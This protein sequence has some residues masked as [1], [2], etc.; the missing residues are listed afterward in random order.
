MKKLLSALIL[1][2]FFLTSCAS[3][4][5]LSDDT[6][7]N[8][9][10]LAT[11]STAPLPDSAQV[12]SVSEDIK[13]SETTASTA[14]ELTAEDIEK[15]YPGKTVITIS[16]N[17]SFGRQDV[18]S[19]A[20]EYLSSIGKD[21]VIYICP[22]KAEAVKSEYC[23]DSGN[24]TIGQTD[25]DSVI[26]EMS[27]KIDI[28][29]SGNYLKTVEKGILLPLDEYIEGSKLHKFIPEKLWNGVR[30]DGEIY[31]IDCYSQ[32]SPQRGY[33]VDCEL[34]DKYGFDP[35]K[36]LIEQLDVLKAI[37]EKESCTPVI[38]GN[39]FYITNFYLDSI[40]VAEGVCL[41]S[42][43][44]IKSILEDDGYIDFLR[45]MFTLR[46]EGLIRDI[47]FTGNAGSFFAHEAPTRLPPESFA[48]IDYAKG[49]DY[50]SGK[51]D[52]V[53]VYPVFTKSPRL[54]KSVTAAG[55]SV[56]SSHPDCAFDFLETVFTDSAL[57]NIMC[58]GNYT[59]N[60]L[61]DGRISEM[62]STSLSQFYN[63][64]ITLPSLKESVNKK[65]VFERTVKAL[66]VN[67]G[68]GFT[69]HA[70]DLAKEQEMVLAKVFDMCNILMKDE[71]AS[72]EE[73]ISAYKAALSDAGLERL[74]E[75]AKAQYNEWRS[76][77]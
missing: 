75:S 39:Q 62:N 20:N 55:I 42:D 56:S 66:V 59:E 25:Y 71:F 64:L 14:G 67:P 47:T 37:D 19:M 77:Q 7:I 74:I 57:N 33:F 13:A 70:G 28:I 53:R 30:I 45:E 44:S 23:D 69:F 60:L 38:T 17:G 5:P 12:T 49:Y 10:S 2:V 29:L 9:D 1:S 73:Y 43:G 63:G 41:D 65:E 54:I 26:K 72:F 8:E 15:L 31:G 16:H 32:I 34:A 24:I 18:I 35:E 51:P 48:A 4:P 46:K 52:F 58:Y 68:I 6:G 3:Q 27:D 11:I 50:L 36:P 40:P 61:E 76:Q 21:Y 22:I